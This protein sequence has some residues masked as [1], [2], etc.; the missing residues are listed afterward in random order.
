[1]EV[2]SDNKWALPFLEFLQN[3]SNMEEL[4]LSAQRLRDDLSV[5]HVVYHWVNSA[6][7]RFGVGTYSTAWVDRYLDRNYVHID[8]VIAGCAQRSGITNWKEFDWSSKT[9]RDFLTDALQH[10]V[11][12]QGLSIPIHG[13]SARFS[14]LTI[15][16]YCDDME[17]EEFTQTNG[18]PLT[19]IAHEIDRK[20]Q[21]LDGGYGPS[22]IVPLSPRELSVLTLL[23]QG[24]SR[25]QA[26]AELDISQHTLRVYIETARNKLGAT[27]TTHAVARALRNGLIVL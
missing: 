10:G 21:E 12:N 22:R 13:P 4:Q 11:G 8:P 9:S 14:I 16:D 7:R 23:A 1:M 5:L 2:G 24:Q 6:G 18:R 26:A 17:W 3:A 27:N 15:N 25:A 19:L 20:A